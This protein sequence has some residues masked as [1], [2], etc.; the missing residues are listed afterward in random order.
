[1]K[2]TYYLEVKTRKKLYGEYM[3]LK[4]LLQKHK[5]DVYKITF[6]DYLKNIYTLPIQ[7]LKEIHD[8]ENTY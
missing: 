6:E 7:I 4:R 8:G 3:V 1:M 2:A 5:A